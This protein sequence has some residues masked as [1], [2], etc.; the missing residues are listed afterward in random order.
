L[1]LC[2]SSHAPLL[3]RHF[4]VVLLVLAQ[5]NADLIRHCCVL[6]ATLRDL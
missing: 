5:S 4:G 2:S 6:N 3:L 1:V